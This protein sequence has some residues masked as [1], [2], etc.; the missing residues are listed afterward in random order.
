M[1]KYAYMNDIDNKKNIVHETASKIPLH[2]QPVERMVKLVSA[3]SKLSSG[4]KRRDGTVHTKIATRKIFKK[5][6]TK[7][8]YI[9]L[10]DKNIFE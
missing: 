10:I 2:S 9:D 6:N 1:I 7:K 5:T 8:D 4:E 3:D